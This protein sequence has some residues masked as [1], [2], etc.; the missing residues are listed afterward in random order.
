M[1]YITWDSIKNATLK[2]ER[3]VCFD[4]VVAA[5]H[6]GR[7]LEFIKHP[8]LGREHQ[9]L[10]LVEIAGYVYVIPFVEDEEKWFLKTMFPSRKY[11][12]QHLGK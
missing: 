10:M 7:L 4:D 6:D 3:G 8:C 11:T 9:Y 5:L 12:K 1:L 2:E